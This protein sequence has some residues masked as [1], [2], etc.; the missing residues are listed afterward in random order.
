M[1][2]KNFLFIVLAIVAVVVYAYYRPEKTPEKAMTLSPKEYI[3]L[4]EKG[5]ADQKG[6]HELD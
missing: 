1:N 2:T 3:Q 4:I 5:K 6:D